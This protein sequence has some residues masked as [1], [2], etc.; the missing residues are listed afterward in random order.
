MCTGEVLPMVEER[1]RGHL[2]WLG[3]N[4]LFHHND[5]NRVKVTDTVLALSVLYNSGL[6]FLPEFIH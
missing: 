6:K 1:R 4:A 3:H 5:N 2:L